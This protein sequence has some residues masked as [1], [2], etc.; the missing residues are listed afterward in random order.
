MRGAQLPA[1]PCR[2]ASAIPLEQERL[3][4][5]APAAIP[6]FPSTSVVQEMPRK[7]QECTRMGGGAST[8]KKR[9]AS[10]QSNSN[11]EDSPPPRDDLSRILRKSL[12]PRGYPMPSKITGGMRLVNTFE[13]CFGNLDGYSE[14]HTSIKLLALSL[15]QSIVSL[16]AFKG[17]DRRFTCT[18]TIIQHTASSMSIL[19]SASLIRSS[20][21]ES[22]I[23]DKLEIKVRLPN[24]KLV[25][26][27]LWKY[28]FYYNIAVVN[29]KAFPEFHAACFHN[30]VPANVK[31]SQS[32][33]V[34]IGRVFESGEL[35]AT[36][37]TL[38]YKTCKFDCQQLMAS[39]CK[40]TKAGIG[41][42]IIDA[43]GKFIGMS[44]YYKDGAPFLPITIL[45]KCLKH[46]NEFG[47]VLQPWHGLRIGSLQAEKL[48]VRE[49]VH[50]ILPHAHG[51]Y[52]Q[53]FH[54]LILDKAESAFRH[55]EG[56]HLTVSFLR[57]SSGSEFCATISAEV[58]DMS[59][60]NMS[61]QNKSKQNSVRWPVPKTKWLYPDDERDADMMPLVRKCRRPGYVYEA[62]LM[63]DVSRY[64]RV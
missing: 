3:L 7:N 49:E 42:P 26:G 36:G 45:Q 50:D 11:R 21:D 18:G 41:G 59:E 52:V 43:D 34:A 16:A 32:K 1:A 17:Q 27:K 51:I 53:K 15:C 38:L 6:D 40:T 20:E 4:Q 62:P 35:M 13:L 54:E 47:R 31:F 12:L 25:V 39:T 10:L 5:S 30:E 55:G 24:G 14:E 64:T 56:M 57:P 63:T 8:S 28:D 46:F 48:R 44:F 37:G 58:I 2:R 23:L 33:L 60:Q 29:T 22:K 19:T 61:S 9:K